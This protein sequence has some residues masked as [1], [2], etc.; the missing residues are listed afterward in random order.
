LLRRSAFYLIVLAL[1][2]S[3]LRPRVPHVSRRPAAGDQSLFVRHLHRLGCRD[4]GNGPGKNLSRRH[5]RV[6]ASLAGF[7]TLVIAH[8]L[9]LA[10]TPWK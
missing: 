2:D 6:V 3:H 1:G 7:V 10:A 4:S 5:W 9:A 8:N